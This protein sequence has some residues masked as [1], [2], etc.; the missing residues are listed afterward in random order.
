M[1]GP[2]FWGVRVLE[3]VRSED[4]TV[5]T[6]FLGSFCHLDQPQ[7]TTDWV[8]NHDLILCIKSLLV[9]EMRLSWK[10][11]SIMHCSSSGTFSCKCLKSCAVYTFRFLSGD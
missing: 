4:G 7:V 5:F 6:H 8:S 2:L 10:S 9:P 3:V 11:P 1:T